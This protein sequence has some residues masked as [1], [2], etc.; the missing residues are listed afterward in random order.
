MDAEITIARLLHAPRDLVWDGLTSPEHIARWWGP[1]GWT[2]TV[3]RMD[4]HPGGVWHYCMRP[5]HDA[6]EEVWG[7]AVYETI[8]KPSQ[9]TYLETFSD[10]DANIVGDSRRTVTLELH[11]RGEHTDLVVRTRFDTVEERE[12]MEKLGMAAG[13][14]MTL[15][16]FDDWLTTST[17][18]GS[19]T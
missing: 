17:A 13:F 11:D 6:T 19:A 7:R 2:T 9:L 16:R 1:K 14:S 4:V 5:D 10:P 18:K 12:A 15:D 3:Y 8:E